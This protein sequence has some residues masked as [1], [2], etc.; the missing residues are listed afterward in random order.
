MPQ[1]ENPNGQGGDT[2]KPLAQR[3]PE[4]QGLS[5]NQVLLYQRIE[6]ALHEPCMTSDDEKLS[7]I[8]G[9]GKPLLGA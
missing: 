7:G 1:T 9:C 5:P 6:E 8:T 4:Q 2:F 3:K